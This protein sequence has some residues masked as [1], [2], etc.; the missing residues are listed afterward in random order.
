MILLDASYFLAL[1]N[2]K[3]VHHQKAKEIAQQIEN[4][5]YGKSFTTDHILDESISVS[6]RKLNKKKS[7][8]LGKNIMDS[9][10]YL[11]SHKH[12]LIKAWMYYEK[13]NEN[14]SFTDCVSIIVCQGFK[15]EYIATFDKAFHNINYIQVIGIPPKNT[16]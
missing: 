12:N 15:I 11:I 7:L 8:L 4:D 10:P 14:F 1:A 2:E 13:T 16:P 5:E 6:R 9:V 3:D